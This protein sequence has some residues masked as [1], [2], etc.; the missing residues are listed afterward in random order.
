MKMVISPGNI[1]HFSW[2]LQL[3]YDSYLGGYRI[4]RTVGFMV[5][6]PVDNATCLDE[7]Q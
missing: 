4:P 6:I 2:K 7:L 1:G 5:D 3:I